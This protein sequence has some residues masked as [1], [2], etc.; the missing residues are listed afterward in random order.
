MASI[1]KKGSSVKKT[2]VTVKSCEPMN[3]NELVSINLKSGFGEESDTSRSKDLG[4][5]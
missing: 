5:N 4:I 3:Q 2:L 1:V